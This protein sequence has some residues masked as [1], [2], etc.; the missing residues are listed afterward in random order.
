MVSNFGASLSSWQRVHFASPLRTRSL[1]GGFA[2]ATG[3]GFS[4]DE[5]TGDGLT[6]TISVVETGA[7]GET[8]LG[9]CAV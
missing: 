4:V 8:V 2:A 3:M 7:A 1:A 9:A 6:G 5:V